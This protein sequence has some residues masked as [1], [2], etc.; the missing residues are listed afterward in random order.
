MTI[1][2]PSTRAKP[3]QS[4]GYASPNP[5]HRP[6]RSY[7]REA[8]GGANAASRSRTTTCWKRQIGS[9]EFSTAS[10]KPGSMNGSLPRYAGRSIRPRRYRG[11]IV[12]GELASHGR[13]SM[14][15]AKRPPSARRRRRTGQSIRGTG[16]RDHRVTLLL[17]RPLPATRSIGHLL[18]FTPFEQIPCELCRGLSRIESQ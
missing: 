10:M 11:R 8:G 3:G 13:P 15:P 2:F 1:V 14:V 17:G 18:S 16:C 9:I 5:W 7:K 12:D 4:P 6:R